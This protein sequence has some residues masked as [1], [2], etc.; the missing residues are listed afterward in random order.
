MRIIL[1]AL[2]LYS[3]CYGAVII[4]TKD[5]ADP[6]LA[7]FIRNVNGT[8]FEGFGSEYGEDYW[9]MN[10]TRRF[11]YQYTCQAADFQDASGWTATWRTKNLLPNCAA[12]TDNFLVVH[13][14][15]YRFEMSIFGFTSATM[16]PGVYINKS[17]GYVRLD[18]PAVNVDE[19]HTYQIIY[20]PNTTKASFYIDGD[21]KGEYPLTS[22]YTTTAIQFLWGD[23]YSTTTAAHENRYTIARL[24]KGVNPVKWVISGTPAAAEGETTTYQVKI[25]GQPTAPVIVTLSGDSQVLVNGLSQAQLTFDNAVL[26]IPVQTVTVTAFDDFEQEGDHFGTITHSASSADAA[27]NFTMRNVVVNIT[28]NDIAGV[29]IIAEQFD[30]AETDTEPVSYDLSLKSQPSSNVTITFVTDSQISP[31]AP[32]VFNGS[33]WNVP[34]TVYIY[35]VNDNISEGPH[36]SIISHT[37]TSSDANYNDFCINNVVVNIEDDEPWCGQAGTMYFNADF[38]RDCYIDFKDIE[39]MA[40]VWLMSN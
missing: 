32:I 13:N 21:V 22:L 18:V 26:P 6:T 27:Y 1:T 11:Y 16:Y 7:G 9:Y 33:N 15:A 10:S 35:V 24:E 37:I 30:V 12:V 36:S 40:S 31:I 14:G 2:L 20:D 4:E 8:T 23:Q 39:S 38:N 29:N 34:Q 5:G 25:C 19:Y 28:D 3:F 17:G